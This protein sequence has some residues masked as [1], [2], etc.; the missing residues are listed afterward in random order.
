M[1]RTCNAFKSLAMLD[2]ETAE[3]IASKQSKRA[4]RRLLKAEENR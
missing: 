1:P 2:D 4:Q 3:S